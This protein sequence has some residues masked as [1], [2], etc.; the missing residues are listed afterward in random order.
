MQ[1]I[2]QM[3]ESCVSESRGRPRRPSC[4]L[5]SSRQERNSPKVTLLVPRGSRLASSVM[6]AGRQ[7]QTRFSTSRSMS[8]CSC[9]DSRLGA[10]ARTNSKMLIRPLVIPMDSTYRMKEA[11][12][13]GEKPRAQG[14]CPRPS[15]SSS[16]ERYPS[17]SVSQRLKTYAKLLLTRAISAPTLSAT[18]PHSFTGAG[19]RLMIARQSTALSSVSGSCCIK[20]AIVSYRTPACRGPTSSSNWGRKA[21]N[22]AQETVRSPSG[23]SSFSRCVKGASRSWRLRLEAALSRSMPS[24]ASLLGEESPPRIWKR[25]RKRT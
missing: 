13:S 24:T 6:S 25:C 7:I 17:R 5:I 10:T 4:T 19:S 9:S 2:S 11:T 22:S 20:L 3:A 23:S 12:S 15:S 16:K 21:P 1:A 14:S 8:W 18:W